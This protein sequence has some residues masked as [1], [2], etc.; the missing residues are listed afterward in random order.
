MQKKQ[1]ETVKNPINYGLSY[2]LTDIQFCCFGR[3]PF[4]F[5]F[6]LPNRFLC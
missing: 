5:L 6:P 4:I 3:E 1:S 2:S